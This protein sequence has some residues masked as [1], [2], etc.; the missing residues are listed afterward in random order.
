MGLAIDGLIS[1]LKTTDL[2]NSLM[3][4][5]AVPQ[6]LLKNKVTDS[7]SFITALQ[8]LNT[9]LASLQTAAAALAKPEGTD[10]HTATSSSTTVTATAGPGAVDGSIDFT[11]DKLAQS[12]VVV[13]GPLTQWPDQPPTLTFV[14][15]D[16]TVKQ[17][18]ATSS[19]LAD[20]AAAI[21]KAGVGVSATR[22][23][24]GLDPATGQ[25]V[26]RLQLSS[27]KTGTEGSFT[28][29]RGT[30]ADV[31][32]GTATNLLS[33]PGAA[34]VRQAQDAEVTLWAGTPAAQK[35]TS[36][37]NSFTDVLPGVSVTVSALST[38]PV[39]LTVARND[40]A[41]SDA[42][43]TLIT[44]VNDI[45]TMI[46]QKQAVSTTTNSTGG[47]VVTGGVFTGEVTA[48]DTNQQLVSAVIDPI[49]GVSPST[50]GISITSDG[51]VT[52]DKDKFA[53]AMAADPEKVKAAVATV[54]Q[55]VAD[56]AK[57]ASDPY[58][59]IVTMKIKGEQSV[60]KSLNDQITDWDTRLSDR[61]SSLERIYANLEVQLSQLQSQS[62]WL[63]G[64][65]S[66]LPSGSAS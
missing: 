12:Q 66:S 21:N 35:V 23:A 48:R 10:L 5:E 43:N 20:V 13:T 58:E 27:A 33:D 22:V 63:S 45:L 62:S 42:A 11:V 14:A 55:R 28:V 39:T 53:A 2:I 57:T 32:A 15:S 7:Q 49:D 41:I 50:Y 6:T 56:A 18:T 44:S 64:Q 29:Y 19:S 30:P 46:A 59:G 3:Q 34:Q 26:Y 60:V 52:F 65:L 61:R 36:S 17:V 31:T 4:V 8:A 16:G 24:A 25:P 54:A 9:K 47:T 1:G 40:K 38:D 51:A 37:T